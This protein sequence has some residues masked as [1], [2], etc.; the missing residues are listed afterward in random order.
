[1]VAPQ[2][3]RSAMQHD[4]SVE[5]NVAE[6]PEEYDL[7]QIDYISTMSSDTYHLTPFTFT[8]F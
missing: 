8:R 1:M 7:L 3:I 5:I 4:L 6:W 2:A